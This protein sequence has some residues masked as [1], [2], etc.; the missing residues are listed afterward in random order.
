MPLV[1][2][3]NV[4]VYTFILICGVA[5]AALGHLLGGADAQSV[6]VTF[7]LFAGC[8]VIGTVY[9][10]NWKR[11]LRSYGYYGVQAQN[12]QLN[13]AG[14]PESSIVAKYS[15]AGG[16]LG[17]VGISLMSVFLG[18]SK[19][20]LVACVSSFLGGLLLTLGLFGLGMNM[21]TRQRWS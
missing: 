12:T 5:F 6:W 17:S 14:S 13:A 1:I 18:V 8:A 20:V 19:A 21:A 4:A 16:T 2:Y 15:A 10:F 7:A 3:N 9:G 11:M